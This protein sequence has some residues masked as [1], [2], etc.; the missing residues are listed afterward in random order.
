MVDKPVSWFL[1]FQGTG[2]CFLGQ[3]GLAFSPVWFLVI[4]GCVGVVLGGDCLGAR[5][6]EADVLVGALEAR[7]AHVS[8]RA[9]G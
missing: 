5:A 8:R 1:F 2:F 9:N 7:Y 4:A 3:W 6:R